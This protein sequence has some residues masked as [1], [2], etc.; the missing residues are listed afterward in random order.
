MER[1]CANGAEQLTSS[2]D[3]PELA[4]EIS[5]RDKKHLRK[6]VGQLAKARHVC[7]QSQELSPSCSTSN[8]EPLVTTEP[9]RLSL[10]HLD[11]QSSDPRSGVYL[12]CCWGPRD[13]VRYTVKEGAFSI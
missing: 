10:R 12:L 5:I 4:S 2:H 11:L 7:Q 9:P 1:F 3:A 8:Q 13:G 6:G